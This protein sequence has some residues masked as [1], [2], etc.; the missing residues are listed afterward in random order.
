MKFVSESGK[1]VGQTFS[2][3][4]S[5]SYVDRVTRFSG[6]LSLVIELRYSTF[7]KAF[8]ELFI[9]LNKEGVDMKYE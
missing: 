9:S 7:Q 8:S 1:G 4:L 2:A 3:D 6:L 5:K